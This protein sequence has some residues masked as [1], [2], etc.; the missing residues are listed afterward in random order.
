MP[1][2]LAVDGKSEKKKIEEITSGVWS[3]SW[4]F[5]STGTVRTH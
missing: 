5:P 4:V 2:L 3:L 1:A